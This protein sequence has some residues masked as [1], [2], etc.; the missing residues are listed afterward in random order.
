MTFPK[1][2][3]KGD[4]IGLVAPS[5]RISAENISKCIEAVEA[6]GYKAVLGSSADKNYMGYLSGDDNVRA[7]DINEMFGRTDISGIFCLRGGYGSCRTVDRLD[8]DMIK[9]NPKVFVGYSDITTLHLV[10]N[11]ACNMITFHAP[12]VSSNMISQFDDYTKKSFMETLFME[13]E[14]EYLNPEGKKIETLSGGC[15]EG[16]LTGG[17]LSLIAASIGTPYEIDTRDKILFI[18]EVDEHTYRIDRF[19]QQLKHSGK[20]DALKGI[21]LGSFKNCDPEREGD[22]DLNEVFEDII[23]P[24]SKPTV[25]DVECGHCYPTGSMPMGAVCKLDADN[26]KIVFTK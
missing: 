1:S 12:M 14:L 20:L 22:A 17:N 6:L 18:E 23:K 15:A 8:L 11:Q 10:L 26:G 24:L 19:L 7:R 5:S 4:T 16:I 25:Y 21:I 2:L 9:N 3:K 13:E